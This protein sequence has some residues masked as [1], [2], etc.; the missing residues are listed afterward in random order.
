MI[1][2]VSPSQTPD[3]LK[4][5]RTL[6]RLRRTNPEYFIDTPPAVTDGDT[7]SEVVAMGTSGG[8]RSPN[9]AGLM[10]RP[11]Q[12]SK[13]MADT[14]PDVMSDIDAVKSMV[15]K[16]H[17]ASS[18]VAKSLDRS[19]SMTAADVTK[20]INKTKE[21]PKTGTRDKLLTSLYELRDKLNNR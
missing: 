1:E 17:G 8:D 21:L 10:S 6:M 11:A 3:P 15:G 20:L 7:A 14:Q 12:T 13:G 5:A 4:T 19:E 16:V 2:P 18:T 9:N